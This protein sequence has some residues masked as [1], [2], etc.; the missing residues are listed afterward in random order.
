MTAA[1]LPE[2]V[3]EPETGKLV[4]F[5]DLAGLHAPLQD[6][7]LARIA[8]VATRSDFVNGAPVGAFEERFA[9][10][11]G[12]RYAVG[13]N[14][15]TSAIHLALMAL[16]IGA[17][18][19]V[20]SV[21]HT[22]VGSVWGILYCGAT[23]VFVDVDP[24]TMTLD[25]RS[26]EAAITP[27]TRAILAVHLYGHPVDMDPLLAIA[28]RHGLAVV[29]DAAQAHGARYKGRPAGSM[30]HLACFSFYPGKNLGAW[31]EGGMVVTSDPALRSRV[32][33]LRDHGQRQ[34]YRHA[35]LGFNYRMDSIQAVVLDAKLDCL[36][37]W[38]RARRAA[39]ACYADELKD[40]PGLTVPQRRAWAEPVHH[41]YVVRH[42]WRDRLREHLAQ[43]GIDTGL[44]YPVPLHRQ[45]AIVPRLRRAYSLPVTE[46]IAEQ[47]LSLPIYPG[48]TAAQVSRVA[49]AVRDFREPDA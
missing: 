25:T 8:A 11:C 4:P 7:I 17:G 21:A 48:L 47:C 42:P 18:D 45:D 37:D 5:Q 23:P 30:G 26:I 34:R 49:A 46:W 9:A 40:I 41:L 31:G 15:G 12:A 29:E 28:Q 33:R 32:A 27:R 16:D 14:S 39:A 19:E 24:V 22:F 36:D 44:H 2:A 3:R 38:N 20:I 10:Y 13:C 35:E 6:A 43:T 1:I